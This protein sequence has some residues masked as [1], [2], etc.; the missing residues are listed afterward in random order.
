MGVRL[1]EGDDYPY[2]EVRGLPEEFVL[3]ENSLCGRDSA[4][5]V[6]RNSTGEPLI[7]C[8]CGNVI[9]G[10]FDPSKPFFTAHGSF[11]TNC[12]TELLASTSEADRQGRT[13]NRCNGEGYESVALMPLCVG[14]QRLGLLQLND[15]RKG[16]F[17]PAVIAL[18]ERLAGHLAVALAKLRA[19]DEVRHLNANLEQ[20]IAE[21]AGEIRKANVVLT[22]EQERFREV[23]DMLPAY[24]VL[25]TPDYYVPFANRFFEERFG[26]SEGRRCYEYLFNRNEPCETCETYTVL[27]TN[28]P[29]HWEWTGPDGRN[30]DI[31][32]FPFTDSD[33][34]PLIM[35][36][37]V[38]ITERK[39]AEAALKEVNRTLEVRVAERTESLDRERANLRAVFDVVNV[40]MLV[41]AEDGDVKQVNDTLSRW[42]RERRVGVGGGATGR[43]RG[44]CP[45]AGRSRRLRT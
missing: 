24:V 42:V 9:C 41:I 30:Y 21:Q 22:R 33:G 32:D 20:R 1:K 43:L 4:G 17:S 3:V 12:T 6:V 7:E 28:A 16:M 40:G 18:W 45:C 31:H 38:D 11:W 8:M 23:L 26:K 15:R 14:E 29:H 44:V 25:L 19:E 37:G 39:R 10:R 36:V 2:Y 13:P 5:A 27:K 34:S 35:E